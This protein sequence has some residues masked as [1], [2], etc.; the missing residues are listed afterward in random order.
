[1]KLKNSLQW[2]CGIVAASTLFAIMVLTFFDVS[3]R[4]L[5]SQSI[6]GS[7][8]ITEMLMVL[9]IFAALPLVSLRGEHVVF[10][11][12]DGLLG[13]TARRVQ[14]LL[15][16]LLCAAA[17]LGIGWLM[18]GQAADIANA[19]ET[20]AQLQIPR[21]PF[22]YAMAVLCMLTGLAHLALGLMREEATED[23]GSVL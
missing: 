7:L 9:V 21:Y 23:E 18:W 14:R 12:L 4:K 8:E 5:L 10:N 1:M 11:S 20:S 6:P 22:V 13:A 17:L 2:L 16:N 15:V 3:G 19:G